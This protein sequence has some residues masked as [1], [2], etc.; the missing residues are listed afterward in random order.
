[1]GAREKW[2]CIS[3]T[4]IAEALSRVRSRSR[5]GSGAAAST[6]TK[7]TARTL[8][9]RPPALGGG[10]LTWAAWGAIRGVAA[11]GRKARGSDGESALGVPVLRFTEEQ[12]LGDTEVTHSTRVHLRSASMADMSL[13][14]AFNYYLVRTNFGGT[15][16]GQISDS[17]THKLHYV[18][19][20][21][22]V[23][24][25]A[26][27]AGDWLGKHQ[28]SLTRLI[29]VA[30]G[31]PGEFFLGERVTSDNVAPLGGWSV[32]FFESDAAGVGITILGCNAAA[33]DVQKVGKYERGQVNKGDPYGL[34]RGYTC[35]PR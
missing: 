10:G 30:H 34:Y 35:S 27:K 12:M 22:S 1:M 6:R 33:D 7:L 29:I 17:A 3:Y 9:P 19:D 8:G 24:S 4:P 23:Y 5:D 2:L 32:P 11:G 13:T 16:T 26:G 15:A 31:K 28:K 21:Q 25:T 20:G 14:P 18:P